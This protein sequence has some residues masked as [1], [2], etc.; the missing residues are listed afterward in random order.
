MRLDRHPLRLVLTI[1]IVAIGCLPYLHAQIRVGVAEVDITPPVGGLT[2]GYSSA[3]PT[4]GVH[5]PVTARILTLESN[6]ARV[7]MVVCDLC[8]YNSSQ[9]HADVRALGFDQFLL[10]NTHTHAGPKMNEEFPSA[11]HPWARTVDERILEGVNQAS[12]DSFVGNFVAAAGQIQL[13]YNRLFQQGNYSITHF[14]NPDH[15]PYGAVDTEVGVIRIDDA[16]GRTRAVLVNYACHPVVLGPRNLKISADFPGVMRARVEE[17]LGGNVK[18]F[19]FQSGAGDINPLFMARG[20]DREGD[21][22]IVS[23]VGEL[24]ATEVLRALSFVKQDVG[25]SDSL[26]VMSSVSQFRQ[27]FDSGASMEMG[28]TSILINDSIAI[29]TMPGEPFHYFPTEFRRQSGVAHNFFLGYCCNGPYDWPRY[30]PDLHSAARGGYGASDTTMAEVGAGERL[31]NTGL[32]QLFTL[33]GRLKSE[34][35]RHLV[36]PTRP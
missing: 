11:E 16:D 27:R 25:T 32:I 26:K 15:I 30:L 21:F 36:E 6:T 3:Q 5:D 12:R 2:T 31:L 33:Q 22:D 9:L 4:D 8:I 10:M 28:S 14:E 1:A 29:M 7:A 18:C 13:G 17:E 23:R 34:P 20:D 24:L 35:I 19:F